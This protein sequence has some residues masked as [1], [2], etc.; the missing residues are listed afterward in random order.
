MSVQ[1]LTRFDPL[2]FGRQVEGAENVTDTG[3][4]SIVV[5]LALVFG[6]FLQ[7]KQVII[8]QAPLLGFVIGRAKDGLSL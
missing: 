3:Y 2:R 6:G 5:T 1:L 8:K 4:G 7:L